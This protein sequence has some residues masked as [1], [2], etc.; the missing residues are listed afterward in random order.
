[1]TYAVKSEK[2][3]PPVSDPYVCIKYFRPQSGH[4]LRR[5]ILLGRT[6]IVHI[7]AHLTARRQGAYKSNFF[8]NLQG[9]ISQH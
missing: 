2:K 6:V 9:V 8:Y 3:G 4:F 1:M 5:E 7:V